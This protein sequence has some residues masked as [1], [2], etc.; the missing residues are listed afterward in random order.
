MKF[1]FEKFKK[2]TGLSGNGVFVL[3]SD[4]EKAAFKKIS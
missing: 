2:V 4:K 1:D 3:R